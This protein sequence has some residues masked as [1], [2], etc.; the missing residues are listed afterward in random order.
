MD[1]SYMEVELWESNNGRLPANEFIE[2]LNLKA[3]KKILWQIEQLEEQGLNLLQSNHLKKFSGYDI[4]ELRIA[5]DRR[6]YRL[7]GVIRQSKFWILHGF[8]KKSRATPSKEIQT[9]L[10]RSKELDMQLTEIN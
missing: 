2:G 6:L 1:C 4:Y 5:F 10:N 9:T 3:Q 7:C 8:Q